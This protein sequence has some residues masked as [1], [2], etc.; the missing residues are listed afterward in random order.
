MSIINGQQKT[1]EIRSGYFGGWFDSGRLQA[2]QAGAAEVAEQDFLFLFWL[3][4]MPSSAEMLGE[5]D[6]PIGE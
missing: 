5:E 2:S 6:R 1:L 3:V 4:V